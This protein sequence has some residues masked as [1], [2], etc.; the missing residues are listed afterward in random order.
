MQEKMH[1]LEYLE[2]FKKLPK[3]KLSIPQT[4]SLFLGLIFKMVLD[5][6]IL[7]KEEI[8]VFTQEILNKKYRDYVYNGRPYLASRIL[9]DLEVEVDYNALLKL[10]NSIVDYLHNDEDKPSKDTRKVNNTNIV[11]WYNSV[12][13]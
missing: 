3:M 7:N 13:E 5:K 12:K 11:G 9:K 4:K 6:E 1:R 2:E 10:S 8:Y